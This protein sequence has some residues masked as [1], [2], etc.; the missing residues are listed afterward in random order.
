MTGATTASRYQVLTQLARGGMGE[1]LLAR[2]LG[3]AGFERL[4][5]L[6][7]PLH[8]ARSP[9]TV[10]A[11]IDEARLLA[12]I[13]HPNVCHVYDLE[14]ADGD[15]FFV[16]EFLD[17]VSLWAFLDRGARAEPVPPR[18]LCALFEQACD[19]LSA[20]HGLRGAEAGVVHRDI[21]PSNVFVTRDGVVKILDLGIA[22]SP[23]PAEPAEPAPAPAPAAAQRGRVRGKPPYCSPEQ[24]AGDRIDARA[25]LFA[26]GLVLH[27]V[28]RGQRPARDVLGAE[29]ARTLE[30]AALPAE[31]AAIVE[32]AVAPAPDDRFAS[33]G[34]MLSALRHAAA[35]YGGSLAR[36]ELAAW[37]T[38]RFARE[39]AQQRA[40]VDR[41]ADG[42]ADEAPTRVLVLHPA[43][44]P[45]A[46]AAAKG[47]RGAGLGPAPEAIGD[48]MLEASASS[49]IEDPLPHATEPLTPA[50]AARFDPMLDAPPAARI[51]A[52]S[53][54]ASEPRPADERRRSQIRVALVAV[55]IGLVGAAAIALAASQRGDDERTARSA[56]PRPADL[57][58]DAVDTQN[59]SAHAPPSAVDRAWSAPDARDALAGQAPAA[60][61]N[62]APGAHA[63]DA[64]A[65]R[66][67]APA[68]TP[69]AS[70]GAARPVEPPTAKAT[71]PAKAPRRAVERPAP[72][73]RTAEAGVGSIR[74]DSQPAYATIDVDG[75]RIGATPIKSWKLPAGRHRIHAR[76]V[77]GREQDREVEIHGDEQTNLPLTW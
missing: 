57:F 21:S 8:V 33:A 44:E 74:I 19:G 60:A 77:D 56:T 67:P 66:V 35:A 68:P 76:C 40:I 51:D 38:A 59:T 12:Q 63:R 43:T 28:A 53:P 65:E 34:E 55:A 58:V 17:G 48:A 31:I 64:H 14:E 36:S 9:E 10:R 75:H 26:L 41:A 20:I 4:V 52:A 23:E 73:P 42:I 45:A 32:R 6:K 1:I 62:A 47:P 30:L 54:H 16:M 61:G 11:L 37:L 7:R 27:D 50:P 25:D 49:T 22:R 69:A 3:A 13:H 46:G 5:V 15:F 71:A 72:A 18:V 29:R 2:R 24:L 39:L 70:A